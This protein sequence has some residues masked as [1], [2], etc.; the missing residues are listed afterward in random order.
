MNVIHTESSVLTLGGNLGSQ[1][2]K[3]AN[4]PEFYELLSSNLYSNPVLAVIR[5]TLTNAWDANL[6]NGNRDPVEVSFLDGV[7][8]IKDHGPGINPN[9]IQEIYCTYGLSTKT[10]TDLTG[11]FGLGCKTPFAIQDVFMVENNYGGKC[12]LYLMQKTSTIPQVTLLNTKDSTEPGLTVSINLSPE[13][14]NKFWNLKEI[15]SAFAHLCGIPVKY[16][17]EL[18]SYPHPNANLLVF[19]TL[20]YSACVAK[21]YYDGIPIKYGYNVYFMPLNKLEEFSKENGYFD[22]FNT[23]LSYRASFMSTYFGLT[24]PFLIRC[25]ANSLDILPSREG[26]RYTDRTFLTVLDTLNQVNI[27]IKESF[28]QDPVQCILSKLGSLDVLINK[29]YSKETI[30]KE[31]K[32]YTIEDFWLF[33]CLMSENFRPDLCKYLV[34]HVPQDLKFN[35]EFY[36][37]PRNNF[38][39]GFKRYILDYIPD[40]AKYRVY[41]YSQWGFRPLNRVSAPDFSG[42]IYYPWVYFD[43]LYELLPVITIL[44]TPYLTTDKIKKVYPGKLGDLCIVLYVK[45]RSSAKE[46]A[47]NLKDANKKYIN[48]WDYIE[49]TPRKRTRNPSAVQPDTIYCTSEYRDLLKLTDTLSVSR[50]CFREFGVQEDTYLQC[51]SGKEIV[52]LKTKT[53]IKKAIKSNCIDVKDTVIKYIKENCSGLEDL[54]V[55][56]FWDDLN[57]PFNLFYRSTIVTLLRKIVLWLVLDKDLSSEYGLPYVENPDLI[58]LANNLSVVDPSWVQEVFSGNILDYPLAKNLFT[59]LTNLYVSD[60]SIFGNYMDLILQYIFKEQR[61][62]SKDNLDVLKYLLDYIFKGD[63]HEN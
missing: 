44:I 42:S 43:I 51:T 50:F 18:F 4:T 32:I 7:L 55:F 59:R 58:A 31:D 11:G 9:K 41:T 39:E 36:S 53:E 27:E 37:N 17:S 48:I 47:V 49:D 40:R 35:S 13:N 33:R 29:L 16:N 22:I 30:F 34:D 19:N 46:I 10:N 54:L 14:C 20:N 8:K 6:E 57:N 26:L 38:K 23:F 52:F 12:Y 56:F 28:I 62:P 25:P 15:Y 24:S 60:S 2:F 63:K 3:I 61:N 45:S 5:E 21:T 1:D